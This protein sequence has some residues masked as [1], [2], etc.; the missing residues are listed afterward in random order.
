M[1][2]FDNNRQVKK[3]FKKIVADE[4]LTLTAVAEKC[5]INSQ[6]LNNRFNNQRLA[7][8]DLK[9]I[10]NCIDYDLVIDFVKKADS[11]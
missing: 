5:G 3:E 1:F 2:V 4:D 10:L 11:K 9:K 6:I 7:L 8:S